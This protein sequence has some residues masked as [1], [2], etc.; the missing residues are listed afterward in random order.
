MA[1]NLLL[2]A[3]HK[4]NK[5]TG[6]IEDSTDESLWSSLG[7]ST[8]SGL[9]RVSNFLDLPGSVARDLLAGEG[10]RSF[11]QLVPFGLAGEGTGWTTSEGRTSGR[12]LLRKH[13]LVGDEDT[14]GNFAGGLA[15]E[16]A[17]DPT[18]YIGLGALTKGAAA[19]LRGATSTA[20]A[21]AGLL[22]VGVPLFKSGS[23]QIFTGPTARK[24]ADAAGDVASKIGWSYPARATRKFLDS[25]VGEYMTRPMQEAAR[26]LY[27][28]K[29]EA[30]RAILGETIG[31]ARDRELN[32]LGGVGPHPASLSAQESI[33]LTKQVEIPSYPKGPIAD[34][35]RGVYDAMPGEAKHWARTGMELD[36]IL[37]SGEKAL[38]GGRR[39][40]PKFEVAFKNDSTMHE[41]LGA[42]STTQKARV[43]EFK[44]FADVSEGVVELFGHKPLKTTVDTGRAA[45]DTAVATGTVPGVNQL[46]GGAL[47]AT[48]DAIRKIKAQSIKDIAAGIQNDFSQKIVQTYQPEKGLE[49]LY[50]E[51]GKEVWRKPAKA[52]NLQ[53][54]MRDRYK[55][56][57]EK[58]FD[59]P[60]LMN[61]RVF[62]EDPIAA[63]QRVA[64]TEKY[65]NLNSQMVHEVLAEQIKSPL[66]GLAKGVETVPVGKIVRQLG[67]TK[68]RSIELINSMMATPITGSKAEIARTISR[69][70]IPKDVA[71]ELLKK[72]VNFGAKEAGGLL[73]T[74]DSM[75]SL[76]KA[77]VLTWPAR[78]VRDV[79][80]GA[81]R[82]AERGWWTPAQ[83]WDS[84]SML[85][86][87]TLTGYKSKPV[88]DWLAA[89]GLPY[90]DENATEALRQMYAQNKGGLSHPE[91]DL[92][93]SQ[94]LS[95]LGI[96][97]ILDQVPGRKKKGMWESVKETASAFLG[98]APG[99]DRNP[100]HVRGVNGATE[101][102]FG[103]AVAGDMVGAYT[104]NINRLSPFLYKVGVLGEDP[105]AAMA[106]I[107]AAQIDYSAHAFTSFEK[108]YLKRLWPFYSFAKGQLPYVAHQLMTEPG[109]RLRNTIRATALARGEDPTVPEY[110]GG[111]SS[112]PLGTLDDGSK[113]FITG[114][115]LMH[116][117]A[118]GLVDSP[119]GIGLE[120]LSRA[121]P[122]IKGPLEFA[123]GQSFFQRGT[124]GGRPMTDLDPPIGRT[125]ANIASYMGR[126]SDNPIPT[127]G[128]LEQVISNSPLARA[129]TTARTITDPRKDV[130]ATAAN[131]LSGVRVT[132]VSVAAQER[133]LERQAASIMRGMGGRTFERPYFSKDRLE[134]MSG[135]QQA[136]AEKLLELQQDVVQ[137]RRERAAQP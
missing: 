28:R 51:N 64:R 59:H 58:M 131:V 98:R 23:K 70:R 107:T 16:I 118:M 136:L 75:T 37:P 134:E 61:E 31:I 114:F 129:V 72:S 29:R 47:K 38:Y 46:T 20:K 74:I 24:V 33:E 50:L 99:T 15:A 116:E 119:Q 110:I 76:F 73:G 7:T 34:A 9:S 113:R 36:D 132:D 109:G 49:K 111:T 133:A 35:V 68:Q 122:L 56:L 88:M 94:S 27:D 89:N 5:K 62:D 30:D 69:S 86:G 81:A 42:S 78:Y 126:K 22:E 65:H 39:L 106:Q 52:A 3:L 79:T 121:N 4:S 87:E 95:E 13:G 82:N 11:D 32:G 53:P 41:I 124:E 55:Q 54:V 91:I 117:D 125:L 137:R 123:T 115:G 130:L 60:E 12:D 25:T 71:D 103:P 108:T 104:D 1:E 18:T 40:N 77:G 66:Y 93:N 127:P 21:G 90:S 84:V 10:F 17:L 8:L 128:I 45:Y 19:G 112:I 102:R 100:L 26:R 57:A 67:Y 101:S 120:L 105:T 44:Q 96:G 135:P 2:K 43:P 48:E 92:S 80:S 97:H 85:H 63:L 83:A 6:S 14:W